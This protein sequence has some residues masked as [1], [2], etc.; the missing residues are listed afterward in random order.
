VKEGSKGNP[1]LN[2]HQKY[3]QITEKW[4]SMGWQS[5]ADYLK[6][7]NSCDT[8]PMVGGVEK[9]MHSYMLEHIDIWKNCLSTPGISRIL[10]MKSAQKQNVIFP[11]IDET[12]KDLFYM[13]QAQI[14]AGPSIVFTRDLQVDHTPLSPNSDQIC[15]NLFGYDCSSLYLA[16]M[17]HSM[18]SQTYVRRHREEGFAPKHKRRY[19]LMYVWLEYRSNLDG[20]HIRTRQNQG[21]ESRV[22]SYYADGLSV[23][24]D[25]VTVYDL[26]GCYFHAHPHCYLNTRVSEDDIGA[27][28]ARDHER[29]NWISDNGY[30]HECI[31]ECEMV[32]LIANNPEL[33]LQYNKL[34]PKFYNN[35]RSRVSEEVILNAVKSD[36]IFGFFIVDIHTP[37]HIK[38]RFDKFP[39][40]F[41]NHIVKTQD[42]GKCNFINNM[43]C[44]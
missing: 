43:Q 18:P 12:D 32:E 30:K 14:A 33:K 4:V 19:I 23:L 5:M 31:W 44:N 26:K 9:L 22:G 17:L 35:H 21:Y 10:L 37:H 13:F 40:L 42:V 39:P 8:R 6:Y 15:K 36:K 27:I 41:G 20:V 2:G 28:N 29:E 25:T 38:A 7:Y 16:Q 11:L 34:I 3:A 24:N 1:P